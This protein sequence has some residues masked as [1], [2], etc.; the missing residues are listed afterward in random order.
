MENFTESLKECILSS[1]ITHKV[2]RGVLPDTPTSDVFLEYIEKAK[3]Q[4]KHRSDFEGFHIVNGPDTNDLFKMKNA[5]K[6]DTFCSEAYEEPIKSRHGYSLVVSELIDGQEGVSKSGIASHVDE[7]DT[8]HWACGGD[9]L[10]IIS[11]KDGDHEYILSSGDV[12]YVKENTL[13]DVKSL[14]KR[15]GIIFCAR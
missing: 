12:I 11:D 14:S 8:I 3:L 9:S 13:H 10:W 2:F 5:K 4:N 1:D 6:F 7:H 15:A